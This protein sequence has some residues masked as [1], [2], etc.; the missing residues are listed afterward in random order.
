M[1]AG[2]S[3]GQ[4]VPGYGGG[5]SQKNFSPPGS[6]P[7]PSPLI[8]STAVFDCRTFQ[9][10][11]GKHQCF[12]EGLKK[13]KN[14]RKLLSQHRQ[15]ARCGTVPTVPAACAHARLPHSPRDSQSAS[16]D[17]YSTGRFCP[18][19]RRTEERKRVI[20]SSC[21]HCSSHCSLQATSSYCPCRFLHCLRVSQMFFSGSF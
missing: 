11:K 2:L 21:V 15:Q 4:G 9:L 8:L 17:V 5:S 3:V 20:L 19:G 6:P 13:K 14:P 12:A 7:G 16:A 1:A 10:N 18:P